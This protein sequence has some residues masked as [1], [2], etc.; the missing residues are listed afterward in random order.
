MIYGFV[1]WTIGFLHVLQFAALILDPDI[2]PD[3]V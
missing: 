3:S 1:K 2:L